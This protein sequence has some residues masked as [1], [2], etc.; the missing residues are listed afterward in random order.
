MLTDK[1]AILER[2]CQHLVTL[3]KIQGGYITYEAVSDTFRNVKCD[4]SLDLVDLV[5]ERL[6]AE[7]IECVDHL[8]ESEVSGRK[9]QDLYEEKRLRNLLNLSGGQHPKD[10]AKGMHGV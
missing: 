1:G 5:Y 4:L 9:R 8:P 6:T 3:G 2:C 10:D 7:G